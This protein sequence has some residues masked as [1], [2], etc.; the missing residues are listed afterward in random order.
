MVYPDHFEQKAGFDKIREWLSKR[1]LGSLGQDLVTEMK[2]Q[3]EFDKIHPPLMQSVEMMD[4]CLNH[5]DFPAESFFDLRSSLQ[6]ARVEGI[7][8]EPEEIFDLRRS[9]ESVKAILRFF[10]SEN[11]RNYIYLKQLTEKVNVFPLLIEAIDRIL[12]KHGKIKDNASPALSSIRADVAKKQG[13]VSNKLHSILK[14]AIE[15][16]W[17]E[18]D[19][20]PAIRDGR[21]VIPV[22]A[23]NKRRIR[24]LIH[25]E[26]ATGKTSYI[27]PVEVVELNNE[28]R[29][30]EF[31]ERREIIKILVEFTNK[32]RPYI[33]DLFASYAFLGTLD[34]I[35]AKALLAIELE[36]CMPEI[37]NRPMLNWRD[38]R[39][40]ILFQHFKQEKKYVIPM[41]MH[42]EDNH[43]IMV[44]SGPNAGGKSVCLSTAGLLQYMF[45]CALLV[46]VA[47]G[48]KFGIFKNIFMDMGDE[49]S[50]ENDLSTYSSHLRNMKYFL[51]HANH[52]SLI[53]IDEFG[54]GT[55]PMM[56]GAIAEAILEKLNQQGVFGIVTTHYTNLKHFAGATQG[57]I[58]AAMLYDPQHMQPL[59]ILEPGQ[60]GSS[61]AFE[62]ARKTGLPEDVIQ[63]AQDKT[64]KDF[65]DFDKNLRI[66]L[67]DKQYW[68]SK[69]EKIKKLEKNL[70]DIHSKQLAELEEIKNSR[71]LLLEKAKTDAR[72]LLDS[73]NRQIE[74]TIRQIKESNAEKE[75]TKDSRKELEIFKTSLVQN[76][77]ANTETIDLK[78]ERIKQ[79]Q[80]QKQQ[81]QQMPG[82]KM[83][84]QI[85]I[86]DTK[87]IEPGDKVRIKG[88][89]SVGEVVEISDNKYTVAFGNMISN[90]SPDKLEKISQKDYRKNIREAGFKASTLAVDI[91][92]RR[93]VFKTGIDIRGK[94]YEEAIRQLEE[95]IDE[96][97]VMGVGEVRILHG[98][99]DGILRVGIRQFLQ[100]YR[101]IESVA[102]EHIERGGAGIS[103]VRFKL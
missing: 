76:T 99:G 64:G 6:R 56:G 36:A 4:I 93:L 29:E 47:K 50:I 19:T 58:N 68:E 15:Q 53:L 31:E 67:R 87:T 73:A 22:P 57:I 71:K 9:L 62:I 91:S 1:C 38:A 59:Y 21:L 12:N 33:D 96:A 65:V 86:P 30:L 5:D 103:L 2:F 90:I 41:H 44:I 32:L 101:E 28:I 82:Q 18:S 27:E 61:F 70:D 48:S 100:K 37:E 60:P 92:K 14:N 80:L 81:K 51:R 77:D 23:A 10:K 49:Q 8:L 95:Y 66:M 88:Q 74:N 39:H 55:E 3:T 85:E 7:F 102:D 75:K 78:I 72:N 20:T 24:G 34:F 97:I 98:K 84:K 52:E 69:R 63:N 79:K 25:D 35:R 89:E 26:S 46:P 42:L 45:Q 40:P 11:A 16:G 13:S 83:E 43:R 94:R 17:A 54:T